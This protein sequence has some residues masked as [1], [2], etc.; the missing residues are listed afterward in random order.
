MKL[1][2]TSFCDII[3]RNAARAS[4]SLMAGGSASG[5]ALRIP[6]GIVAWMSASSV[7]WPSTASMAR[8]SASEGPTWR[9]TN[10]SGAESG[11]TARLLE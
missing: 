2:H 1:R 8:T 6:A 4:C 3:W 5:F 7:G 10:V 11:V 9:A